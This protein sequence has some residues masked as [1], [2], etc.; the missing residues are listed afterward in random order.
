LRLADFVRRLC[1]TTS[2][3]PPFCHTFA[4]KAA[5]K[6]LSLGVILL[7][8][9]ANHLPLTGSFATPSPFAQTGRNDCP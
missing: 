2:P 1:E 8:S 6:I 9:F 7:G 4:V 5:A 3:P